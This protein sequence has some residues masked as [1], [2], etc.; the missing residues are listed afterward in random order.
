MLGAA[1]LSRHHLQPARQTSS[2]ARNRRNRPVGRAQPRRGWV[3]LH[4]RRAGSVRAVREGL[5]PWRKALK[6][7]P[8]GRSLPIAARAPRSSGLFPRPHARP[9]EGMP[10]TKATRLTPIRAS[11]GAGPIKK[12]DGGRCRGRRH[13]CRRKYF[14]RSRA[15]Q[16][17]GVP[18]R[19]RWRPAPRRAWPVWGRPGRDPVQCGASSLPGQGRRVSPW[20]TG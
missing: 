13:S 15:C 4:P 8:M 17:A 16:P 6:A 2:R 9:P 1:G 10:S 19:W 20:P 14:W 11:P 12:R 7:G 3:S 18:E 5:R